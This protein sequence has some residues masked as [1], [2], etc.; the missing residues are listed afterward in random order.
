M[1]SYRQIEQYHRDGYTVLENLIDQDQL[2]EVRASYEQTIEAALTLGHAQRNE[3][4]GRLKGHR[5]QNPHHPALSRSPLMQALAASDVVKFARK[6]CGSDPAMLGIAAFAMEQ[7][8]DYLPDWHRDSYAAWGKDSPEELRVRHMKKMPA[9]QVLLALEDDAS[10]WFVPGSHNRANTALEEARFEE[11]R[12]GWQESFEGAIQVEV[13]A[14][15]AVPFDARG[16]HRGLKRSGV[17]RRSLFVVYG[18]VEEA[19]HS[20]ISGW[21]REAEYAEQTYLESLP[22]NFRR[23]VEQTIAAVHYNWVDAR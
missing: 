4:T 8:F 13:A 3:E 2:Q 23:A 17:R 15:S 9:T 18:T 22:D 5:F 21:A 7:D 6:V 16:I 10:F 1:I 12:T 19:R 20:T 11:G 14:G